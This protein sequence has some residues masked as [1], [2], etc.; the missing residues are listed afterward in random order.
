M[1][2]CILFDLDG[3][4]VEAK[5][6]HYEA[7]NAALEKHGH[8]AIPREDHLRDFDGLPTRV[9]LEK[10][11]IV[12]AQA[13]KINASKQVLT[14]GLIEQKCRPDPELRRELAKLWHLGYRMAVC[15]NAVR[16]SCDA[17]IWGL[18]VADYLWFWISAE[19]VQRTKP[20]PE[21][22]RVAM[23][24]FAVAPSETVVVEDSAVGIASARASGAHV[25]TV[26]SPKDVI[27][28]DILKFIAEV[29]G[30]QY[31]DA[32]CRSGAPL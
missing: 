22:W 27:A 25:Y 19:E 15:S 16:A 3:T 12:G 10:L 13:S 14:Q 18:G 21:C 9:K 2:C 5:D 24:T 30:A 23:E 17:M 32:A 4:L 31:S 28:E 29:Q 20:D 7:L 8:P 11:G 6:W 1:I 26:V